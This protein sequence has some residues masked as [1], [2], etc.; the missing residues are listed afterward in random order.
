MERFLSNQRERLCSLTDVIEK[1]PFAAGI[2]QR[3][4]KRMAV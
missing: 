4:H 2:G 3:E 1:A